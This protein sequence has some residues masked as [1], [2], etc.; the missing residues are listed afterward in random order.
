MKEL[1]AW[2]EYDYV[3]VNDIAEVAADK[4]YAVLLSSHCRTVA[5]ERLEAIDEQKA[6]V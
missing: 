1:E 2:R 5:T 4:L 6:I 3:I